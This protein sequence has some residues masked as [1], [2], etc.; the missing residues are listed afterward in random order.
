[1]T[2]V[3]PAAPTAD[4]DAASEWL[5]VCGVDAVTP[6]RGVAALVH[7]VAVAIFRLA[8]VETDAAGEVADEQWFG[9]DH[10]DPRTGA[11]VMA[12]SLIHI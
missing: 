8:A 11:P 9:V 1:M 10:V 12:L 7:G 2:D 4:V 6:D 5:D 3:L